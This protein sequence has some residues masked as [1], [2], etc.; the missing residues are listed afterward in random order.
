L[1]VIEGGTNFWEATQEVDRE[2]EEDSQ[3]A[4]DEKPRELYD[5]RRHTQEEVNK[6]KKDGKCFIFHERDTS[7]SIALTGRTRKMT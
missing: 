6:F 4:S 5:I 7:L 1:N 3:G 2:S